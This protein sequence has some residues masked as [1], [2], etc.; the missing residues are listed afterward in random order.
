MADTGL[1]EHLHEAIDDIL[2]ENDGVVFDSYWELA[3]PLFEGLR[4]HGFYV[5]A[6]EHYTNVGILAGG[7]VIDIEAV[8]DDEQGFVSVYTIDAISGVSFYEDS[9]PTVPDSENA[10]L[11]MVANSKHSSEILVYWMAYT[12]EDAQHLAEFGKALIT[13]FPGLKS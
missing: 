13:L 3:K 10:E 12:E 7:V 9:V 5:R 11:V 2:D 4:V 8:E 6:E 1:T